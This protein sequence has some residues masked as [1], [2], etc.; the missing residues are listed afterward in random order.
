MGTFLTTSRLALIR[1]SLRTARLVALL[2]GDSDDSGTSRLRLI[3]APGQLSGMTLG[4]TSHH[5]LVTP[6][7]CVRPH[8]RIR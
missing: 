5:A 6:D 8:D 2:L 7:R 3:T 4:V 1:G